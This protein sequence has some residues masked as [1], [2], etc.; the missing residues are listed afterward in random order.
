MAH[1]TPVRCAC[2]LLL[3][4]LH[5]QSAA[6]A[7]LPDEPGRAQ[8]PTGRSAL[9]LTVSGGVSL[10]AYEAGYL[11]YLSLLFK[12]NPEHF[13][14]RIFT[15]ASA[16]SANALLALMASCSPPDFRPTDGLFYRGWMSLGMKGLFDGETVSP[17]AAF[18]R[19]PGAQ[20]L[21]RIE[22]LWK[23]GLDARCDAVLGVS[24][25]RVTAIPVEL[26]EQVKV[27]RTSAKFVLRIRGR[28][29]GVPPQLTNY[30]SPLNE[31]RRPLLPEDDAGEVDFSALRQALEASTGFPLA[32]APRPVAHCPSNRSAE[33][34]LRC[35]RGAAITALFY[36]GG[37]FDNQPLRLATQI[38]ARGLQ[39]GPGPRFRDVPDVRRTELPPNS[40]FLYID[41]DTEVLPQL[42]KDQAPPMD[43]ALSYGAY[44]LGQL[45]D[46]A[47]SAELQSLL[48]DSPEMKARLGATLTYFRPLSGV[49]LNFFGFFEEDLRIHDFSLGMHD[50]ARFTAEVLGQW[51][52]KA[53]LVTPEQAL[54]GQAEEARAQWKPFLCMRAVLS[55]RGSPRACEALPNNFLAGLQVTLE[56]VYARCQRVSQK[57]LAAGVP[58]PATAHASCQAAIAGEAPPQ[59][60][61]LPAVEGWRAGPDESDFDYE[62]RRLQAHRFAFKDL[63]LK[64]GASPRRKIAKQVIEVAQALGRSERGILVPA[65]GRAYA[66]SLEYVPPDHSLM[67][68][69]GASLEVGYSGTRGESALGWLRFHGSVGVEGLLTVLSPA[70]QRFIAFSPKVGF[71]LEPLPLSWAALQW[72]AGVRAGF[73]FSSADGFASTGC[74]Q[75]LRCSR[76]TT[77]A[78]AAVTA[79]QYLR[80][81]LGVEY[82]PGLRGLP[83]EVSL[84]P[85]LGLQLDWP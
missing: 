63:G 23:Q 15:G 34:T 55:G 61:G 56:R 59:V 62:V 8:G 22:A 81:Q 76:V 78:W 85:T 52:P 42:A 16:G 35:P 21:D 37:V 18:S 6:A 44:L 64:P 19:E 72:R 58:V 31:L 2:W 30:V 41:P 7:P 71:E 11:Y 67:V 49:L 53:A 77:E 79:F 24:V 47:R 70:A 68:L 12:L 48:D 39:E 32:F 51:E 57:A 3:L 1:S 13:E 36:D 17:I 69:V 74:A 65:A 43:S 5:L 4:S 14:P 54:E 10:G 46:S 25:T 80:L 27:P 9:G 66:Q 20:T 83:P 82:L 84:R 40:R 60:P 26:T 73:L 28:G 29:K 33:G 50:A 75:P 45:V 38:G